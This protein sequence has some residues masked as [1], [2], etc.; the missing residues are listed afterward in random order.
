MDTTELTIIEYKTGKEHKFYNL[1][2]KAMGSSCLCY[3]AID[4]EKRQYLIKEFKATAEFVERKSLQLRNTITIIKNAYISRG[5]NYQLDDALIGYANIKEK[6]TYYQVFRFVSGEELTCYNTTPNKVELVLSLFLDLLK[7]IRIFHEDLG[8]LHLDI[9]PSNIYTYCDNPGSFQNAQLLDFDSAKT[10]DEFKSDLFGRNPNKKFIYSSSF[11]WYSTEDFQK[12]NSDDP[13]NLRYYYSPQKYCFAMD[14]TACARVFSFLL[15]RHNTNEG[16]KLPPS[17]EELMRYL[18]Q[19]PQEG[20]RLALERFFAKAFADELKDRYLNVSDMI[21]DVHAIWD[22]YDEYP[23]TIQGIKIKALGESYC[24]SKIKD[25]FRGKNHKTNP[26]SNDLIKS[27]STDIL[28]PIR[29]VGIDYLDSYYIGNQKETPLDQLI[30]HVSGQAVLLIG[31]AGT[32][33]STMCQLEYLTNLVDLRSD[34]IYFYVPLK[35]YEGNVLST[36][37]KTARIRTSDILPSKVVCFFDGFDE[38]PERRMCKGNTSIFD[39]KFFSEIQDLSNKGY[40]CVVTSRTLPIL[41][42][43]QINQAIVQDIPLPQQVAFINHKTGIQLNLSKSMERLLQNA[44]ML[45]IFTELMKSENNLN[46]IENSFQLL[47]QYFISIIKNKKNCTYDFAKKEWDHIIQEVSILA[48]QQNRQLYGEDEDDRDFSFEKMEHSWYFISKFTDEYGFEGIICLDYDDKTLIFSHEIFREF[49]VGYQATQHFLNILSKKTFA[50]EFNALSVKGFFIKYMPYLSHQTLMFISD[51]LKLGCKDQL[52]IETKS[53]NDIA[54]DLLEEMLYRAKYPGAF[55]R[56]MRI[57]WGYMSD[58]VYW[59]LE[60]FARNSIGTASTQQFILVLT[61]LA[62]NK[63]NTFENYDFNYHKAIPYVSGFSGCELIREITLHNGARIVGKKAF[64][65]CTNLQNV[66]LSESVR[67]VDSHAFDGCV[68]LKEINIPKHCKKLKRNGAV[69]RGNRFAYPAN[70]KPS[71]IEL[72]KNIKNIQ[73]GFVN[74][75]NLQEIIVHNQ[76][77]QVI[78]KCLIDTRTQTLILAYGDFQIPDTVVRI[79]Q[80]AFSGNTKITQIVI[81]KNVKKIHN[82]AFYGC[83]NLKEIKTYSSIISK[84]KFMI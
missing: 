20:V 72:N 45:T 52:G 38:I 46:D 31:Q 78:N 55:C 11:P 59:Y 49:F 29:H 18:Y 61:Q 51:N 10:I 14:L 23:K 80:Y 73:S 15:C 53:G 32:A 26:T 81:P 76:R 65:N 83:V 13:R 69:V 39:E 7:S 82:S 3:S 5:G 21:K 43:N 47:E 35:E 54:E 28:P 70:F 36:I 16:E 37:E 71:K 42:K 48:Y 25:A 19:I 44:F 63:Q 2:N 40:T 84:M 33:K 34:K 9:K 50:Q 79:G 64:N 67:V 6:K 41:K 60:K 22:S 12:F 58:H 68:S 62:Y 24:I 74:T 17:Q 27:I 8:M 1:V 4:S 75:Q 66:V 57:P 30:Q 77:Y 56:A